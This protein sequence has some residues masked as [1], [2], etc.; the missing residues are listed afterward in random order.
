[1]WI[2]ARQLTESYTNNMKSVLDLQEIIKF[3]IDET[4]KHLVKSDNES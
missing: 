1:M 4:L 2:R 3:Q